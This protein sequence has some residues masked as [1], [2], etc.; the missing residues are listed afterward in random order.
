MVDN[1]AAMCNTET[2]GGVANS[3]GDLKRG[4]EIVKYLEYCGG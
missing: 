3:Y 1:Y 2:R 4:A